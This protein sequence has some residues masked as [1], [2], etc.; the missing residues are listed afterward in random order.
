[1]EERAN[2]PTAAHLPDFRGKVALVTGGTTGIGWAAAELF[3]RAGAQVVITGQNPASLE[4]ARRKLPAD[5]I[6]LRADAR[7]VDDAAAVAAELGR[8]FGRLDVA[9]LNAGVAQLAPIEMVDE[10]HY[11][12]HMDI[13]VKGV[14]FTLQKVLPLMSAGGSVVV[15]TSVA[16]SKGSP[17]LG[18]YG[19]SKAAV[20]ALVRSLAVE[21]A[22]RQIRVNAISPG[23]TQT[24]IQEKFGLPAEMLVAAEK[25][26]SARIPLGRYGS[27]QEIAHVA[28]FLASPAASF[29]TGAEIPVDGGLLAA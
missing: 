18:I 9:F 1:M 19:A 16:G 15:T 6:T 22:G 10:R 27:P 20:A 25:Q 13:N 26:M 24:P 8:R 14:V 28:L 3:H 17:H 12:D 2:T 5:V 11:A 23:P 7:S 29:I 4:E 21:L